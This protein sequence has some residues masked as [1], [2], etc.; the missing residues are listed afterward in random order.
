MTIKYSTRIV[1]LTN[2]KAIKIPISRRGWLQGIN[3]QK[4]WDKYQHTNLLVPLV[5]SWH[6]IVCQERAYSSKIIDWNY[7]LEIKKRIP[8]LQI[9]NCDLFKPEQWGL[10][11][12]RIVLL[13]YGITPTVAKMY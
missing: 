7:P 1:I 9:D 11:K 12:G 6:G 8:E 5:W 4:L 2:T 13:D 10:Y 3:E